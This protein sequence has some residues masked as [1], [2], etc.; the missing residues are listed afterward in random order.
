MFKKFLQ[1]IFLFCMFT[2]N[3]NAQENKVITIVVPY[4]P[5][6]NS[7]FV[8]RVY[9]KRIEELTGQKII[10][11]NKAGAGGSIGAKFVANSEPNG[12][13][14]CHCDSQSGFMNTI[15]GVPGSHMQGELEP[16]IIIS[17]NSL[18]LAVPGNPNVDIE[19]FIRSINNNIVKFGSYGNLISLW[20]LQFSNNAKAKETVLVNFKGEADTL[21]ALSQNLID[22]SF[23]SLSSANIFVKNKQLKILAVGEEIKTGYPLLKELLDINTTNFQA[24]YVPKGTPL[25]TKQRLN[26][27]F[28]TLANDE[29]F[30][31]TM[32]D[33]GNYHVGGNLD[34]ADDYYKKFYNQRLELFKKYGKY[35]D[36]K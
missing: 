10:I 4:G 13:T 31:K 21:L 15:L 28:S 14:L 12:L 16:I 23:V 20:G 11:L 32:L 6:G 7:D 17:Q 22:F 25:E 34:A 27:L 9:S 24:I 5:G 8:S 1:T 33:R 19:S 18:V 35:L 3:I 26:K 29:N 2:I 36:L 30:L